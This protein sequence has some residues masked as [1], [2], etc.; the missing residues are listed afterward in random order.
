M[1]AGSPEL[2]LPTCNRGSPFSENLVRNGPRKWLQSKI[3]HLL[4]S[5]ICFL[6][7]QS[8]NGP[9]L[10]LCNKL[11]LL[12]NFTF[13]NVLPGFSSFNVFLITHPFFTWPSLIVL[14]VLFYGG[15]PHLLRDR[16]TY[17]STLQ[18][19]LES[20]SVVQSIGWL[21]HSFH[22][23]ISVTLQFFLYSPVCIVCIASSYT[24]Q[25]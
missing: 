2:Q 25:G 5:T 7:F 10:T 24:Q 20:I 19:E 13:S 3:H 6:Y 21:N 1:P 9:P 17:F 22:H 15:V 11:R 4:F 18:N 23:A 14:Q 12:C 16:V 8:D